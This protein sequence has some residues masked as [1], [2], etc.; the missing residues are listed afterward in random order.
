MNQRRIPT[1]SRTFCG[2]LLATLSL[3]GCAVLEGGDAGDGLRLPP[4]VDRPSDER[5]PGKFVWHDLLT[6]DTLAA[7]SFYGDLL[8][9]S[10]KETGA[11]VE[12]YNGDHKI[13]GML[14]IRPRQENRV[15]AQWLAS[16]SVPDVEEAVRQVESGG[17]RIINGPMDLGPRGRAALIEDPAGAHLLLLQSAAGDPPDREPRL[18]DWLWNEVWTLDP[19]ATAAFY[20]PLGRYQ[21][22]LE[23]EDYRILVNEGH[24]RAGIRRIDQAGYAGR[25]VPVIRVADP[26]AL[27]E[28]VEQLGGTVWVRPGEVQN[29]TRTAL[30]SD[31]TGALIMLQQWDFQGEGDQ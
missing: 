16:M 1:I 31:N 28:K 24:W 19:D 14:A 15:E 27:L 29:G 2:L 4:I 8:G 12:I 20:Q 3:A 25:W 21:E 23:G 10:F 9:W 11:Y 7:R 26:D 22:V 17:G 13:G 30:I 5:H 6:P 18:G